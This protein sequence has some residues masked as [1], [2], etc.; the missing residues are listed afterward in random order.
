MSNFLDKA[1][2]L[3]RKKHRITHKLLHPK[4]QKAYI[5]KRDGRT[6]AWTILAIFEIFAV[7]FSNFRTSEYFEFAVARDELMKVGEIE[8]TMSLVAGTATHIATVEPD[9]T[10][11]VMAI[12]TGDGLPP[13]YM[14]WTWRF[15]TKQVSDTFDP[16]ANL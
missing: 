2:R 13:Y 3:M 8:R 15:F 14:D 16:E 9:G 11:S 4:G 7:E 10:N 6:K 5:L 1:I 12:R